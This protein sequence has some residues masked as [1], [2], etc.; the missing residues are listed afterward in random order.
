M[1]KVRIFLSLFLLLTI[2]FS[3]NKKE[4][5]LDLTVLDENILVEGMYADISELTEI[6]IYMSENILYDTSKTSEKDLWTNCATLTITPLDTVTWPKSYNVDFGST[7]CLCEDGR[8]RR[9][10]VEISITGRYSDSATVITI[11]YDNYFINNNK[12][13]ASATIT[14]KGLST[15]SYPYYTINIQ[16]AAVETNKGIISWQ[17]ERIKT[18]VNGNTSPWP[19]NNDDVFIHTGST[20]GTTTDGKLFDILIINPLVTST[21]CPW[22]RSG[23]MEIAKQNSTVYTLDFGAGDCDSLATIIVDGESNGVS[24]R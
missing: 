11:S 23:I 16:N 9:G 15:V 8:Y 2:L 4:T 21:Y 17:A 18:W 1:R 12:M 6:Y 22:I 10:K 14:N 7:D 20:H 19:L 5:P 3:C 24:L 13:S